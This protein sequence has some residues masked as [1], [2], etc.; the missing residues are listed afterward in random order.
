LKFSVGDN[1]AP[2]PFEIELWDT[3]TNEVTLAP[4]P[5]GYHEETVLR[6]TVTTLDETSVLLSNSDVPSNEELYLDE[7]F[8]FVINFGWITSSFEYRNAE[9]CF[10]SE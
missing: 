5:P 9:W 7:M 10:N 8:Q 3:V 2:L 6:P 4:H 1:S